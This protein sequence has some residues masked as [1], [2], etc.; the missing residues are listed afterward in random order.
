M[1]T[2]DIISTWH[3]ATSEVMSFRVS[4]TENASRLDA[5]LAVSEST[6]VEIDG[7]PTNSGAARC[8]LVEACPRAYMIILVSI[9]IL[10]GIGV[11]PIKFISANVHLEASEESF[12]FPGSFGH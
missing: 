2:N 9:N 1:V 5:T 10:P 8:A 4:E 3:I 6:C 12:N 7:E 11:V